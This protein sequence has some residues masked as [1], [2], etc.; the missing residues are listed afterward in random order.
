MKNIKTK[1]FQIL[2][3]IDLVWDFMTEVCEPHRN[4]GAA[5][6]FF[7][8]AVS[9]SWMNKDYL[10]LDRLWFDGDKTVGFVYTEDPVTSV[11][12]N[13]R[14]G[15]EELADEMLEYAESSFP[16]VGGEIEPVIFSGQT[17]L[18]RAAEKRGYKVA[19][20]DVDMLFDFKSSELNH[21]LPEGFHFVDPLN[22]DPLKLAK[23]T[24]NGFNAEELGAFENWERPDYEKPWDPH[25]AYNGVLSLT[26][27]PPPH[28]SYEYN[29]IIADDNDDYVCFSGMWWVPENRLAYMEP[30]C[31]VPEYRKRGLAS[32]ALTQH[33]RRLKPLGAEYM[34]GGGSDFYR[35]IGYNDCVRQ[36]HFK[37]AA[38]Q[39]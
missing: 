3:D 20:E 1:Q 4:N 37:K 21:E 27:A 35:K 24:W 39:S 17:A 13:L 29:V 8:Y 15:Y 38:G 14:S 23:C 22:A 18:I 34:T 6:P 2:T 33:Y 31:T 12:F 19:Y 25:R 32:A 9:S 16:T 5:A 26:I 30:L 11:Y 7:E 36:L 10:H 28:S